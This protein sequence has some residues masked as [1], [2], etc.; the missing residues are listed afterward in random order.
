MFNVALRAA[1]RSVRAPASTPVRFLST[2]SFAAPR[3]AVTLSLL[4]SRT[5]ASGAGLD[6]DTITA[7]VLE[8]LKSFEK[9]DGGKV[10]VV[11]GGALRE[12]MRTV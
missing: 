4:Q 5:Y 7:R 9:V 2:R 11:I 10:G 8:L 3:P 1:A 6:K 12:A